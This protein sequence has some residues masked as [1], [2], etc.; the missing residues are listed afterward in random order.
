MCVHLSENSTFKRQP[1]RNKPPK[2]WCEIIAES[3][4]MYVMKLKACILTA[5]NIVHFLKPPLK[6]CVGGINTY[7]RIL[8]VVVRSNFADFERNVG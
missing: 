7:E 6:P 3:K 2:W 1:Q 4:T 5:F 8:M